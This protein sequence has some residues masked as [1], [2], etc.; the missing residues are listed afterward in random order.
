D[1]LV[2]VLVTPGSGVDAGTTTERYS[3]DGASN[4]VEAEDD[5][6][7]VRRAYDSL[8]NLIREELGSGQPGAVS[9]FVHD[10]L[11]ALTQVRYPSG[12]QVDYDRDSLGRLT[13]VREAGTNLVTHRFQGD[14]RLI[15]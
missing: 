10:A 13:A 3:Y 1:R 9:S 5:D 8:G 15:A 14:D 4:L 7:L 6:S 2:Q 11:G 12:R